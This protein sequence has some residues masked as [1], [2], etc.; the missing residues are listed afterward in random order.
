MYVSLPSSSPL[1]PSTRKV[2]P[3]GRRMNQSYGIRLAGPPGDLALLGLSFLVKLD[4]EVSVWHTNTINPLFK[5]LY[6]MY[7][8]HL[9]H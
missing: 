1:T 7:D 2:A 3:P 9:C 5:K 6:T 8:T 4:T